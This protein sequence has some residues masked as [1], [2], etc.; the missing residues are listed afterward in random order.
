MKPT[1]Q[2]LSTL[3]VVVLIILTAA[4]GAPAAQ[5]TAPAASPA[6][7]PAAAA[8][9]IKIGALY[10]ITGGMSSIDAP[11]L[12]GMKLAVKEINAAGG[13]LGRQIELIAVDGKTD[14]TTTTNAASE[15]IN[16]HKVVAIGGLN[17]ST[18][19]LAAGP[20]AQQ[21]GIPFVTAGA[22][23][24]TLPE[25]IGDFFFMA[26]FGDDAQAFAIADYAIDDLKA[27]TAY[28][29]VD[30][31]YD[32]TTALAA[33]FKQRFTEKGGQIVLEDIYRSGD[34]DF[35]AQIA[36]V[37]ALNPPPDVL[38]ISAIPNE[39]G[40]TT[41]QFREAGLQMPIISGDGFDT[42]L[43]AEVAGE[44]ADNVFFSTHV[45]LDNVDPK[46][47]A[48]VQ[49]YTQEYG[50]P[51]ENAFAVLGYDTLNLIAD[52]IK[53]AGSADP[54]AIRD[55][56]AATQGFAAVTGQITYAPGQRKPDKSVTIIQVQDGA[57]TF[58]KEITP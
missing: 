41:R 50:K 44:L 49:A 38:F 43:I 11:G 33:F 16:V 55:A 35:S 53:R 25:Q 1:Q 28:M 19:A 8:E 58:V 13:V 23:L 21:A 48:F 5:P 27:K 45:A 46:V 40:I 6:A 4:C 22:T 36:K 9:A 24:P 26:P 10:G 42:P 30:Q 32:F 31:A 54:K 3:V 34:T 47:Q 57:Y 17:D 12:N 56:L 39:A 51:P 2:M 18:F 14:Q 15:L 7:S 29:L 52:A 37:Q 20:I